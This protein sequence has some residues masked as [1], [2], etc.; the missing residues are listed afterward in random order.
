MTEATSEEDEV[1]RERGS[2]MELVFAAREERLQASPEVVLGHLVGIEV[3]D[4]LVARERSSATFLEAVPFPRIGVPNGSVRTRDGLRA[5]DASAIEDQDL[6]DKCVRTACVGPQDRQE[7]PQVPFLVLRD[8]RD[9][10]QRRVLRPCGGWLGRRA[11]PPAALTPQ[12]Q[13][14]A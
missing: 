12:A 1:A 9:A 2:L 10:D 7:P 13:S 11:A 3:E 14:A 6:R 5:I 8:D 4:P